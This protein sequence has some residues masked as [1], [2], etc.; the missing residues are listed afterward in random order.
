MV[1]LVLYGYSFITLKS[2]D[3]LAFIFVR[4][5]GV[6]SHCGSDDKHSNN[7]H[8]Y[9]WLHTVAFSLLQALCT[10]TLLVAPWRS[11]G[12]AHPLRWYRLETWGLRVS[13]IWSPK[14]SVTIWRHKYGGESVGYMIQESHGYLEYSL[15]ITVYYVWC[16][17]RC[18]LHAYCCIR[19]RTQVPHK[20]Y[21]LSEPVHELC[22]TYIS[23]QIGPTSVNEAGPLRL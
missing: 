14:I 16:S 10:L 9:F 3:L 6:E 12:A 1:I 17:R 23:C 5:V 19:S 22:L 11:Y 7:T 15:V 8:T 18:S 20:T 13:S 21:A 4:G 2:T